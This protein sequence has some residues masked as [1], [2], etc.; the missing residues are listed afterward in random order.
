MARTAR[1]W[2]SA[3]AIVLLCAGSMA[4]PGK[5]W[6]QNKAVAANAGKGDDVVIWVNNSQTTK[7]DMVQLRDPIANHRRVLGCEAFLKNPQPADV[8]VVLTSPDGR[9]RFPTPA[10]T[11]SA[12]L[13]LPKAGGTKAFQI[14]GEIA[15]AAIGDA[16]IEAH[17]GTATGTVLGQAKVT[18]FSFSPSNMTVT[19]GGNYGI[20]GGGCW[21]LVGAGANFKMS[22]TLVPAAIPPAVGLDCTQPQL[23]NLRIGMIQNATMSV[24]EQWDKPLIYW[25]PN[26]VAAGTTVTETTLYQK[27]VTVVAGQ[28]VAVPADDP[29]YSQPNLDPIAPD[30]ASLMPPI[31]CTGGGV[32][33]S[34]DS[35]HAPVDANFSTNVTSGI[36][37]YTE[38]VKYLFNDDFTDWCVS[39]DTGDKWWQLLHE[40]GWTLNIDSTVPKGASPKADVDPSGTP[41]KTGPPFVN[42]SLNDPANWIPGGVG[43]ATTTFT[44]YAPVSVTFN[45]ANVQGG[46]GRT[47][48]GTVMLSPAA[49]AGGQVV[50]LSSDNPA[51]GAVPATV[52]VAAGATMATFTVTTTTVAVDTVVTITATSCSQDHTGFL[53]VTH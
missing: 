34:Q 21:P 43:T 26:G 24:T 11:T 5:A 17:K 33:S 25:T 3:F 41:P 29:V 13:N 2:Y 38:F 48:T 16:V 7:D 36:V 30:P 50:N 12:V 52:T 53:T 19:A 46:G 14:S 10:D 31:G 49:P 45:P 15:S 9:L 6:G 20:I 8:A 28:D 40:S 1:N 23:K 4:L 44:C 18:V 22:G 42:A 35:P 39:F 27:V 47:S 32:A 51:T 37:V